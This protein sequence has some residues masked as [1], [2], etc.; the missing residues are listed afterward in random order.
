MEKI[1]DI[2]LR[3]SEKRP[4]GDLTTKTESSSG[5]SKVVELDLSGLRQEV[6][7]A[8]ELAEHSFEAWHGDKQQPTRAACM[9]WLEPKSARALV[10][11]SKKY[12]SGKSYAAAAILNEWLRRDIHRKDPNT[13]IP[14]YYQDGGRILANGPAWQV[15][16]LFIKMNDWFGQ[17]KSMLDGQGA[18]VVGMISMLQRTPFLVMDDLCRSEPT[19]FENDIIYRIVD[20]RTNMRLPFIATTNA[21]PAE[22]S[23]WLWG[24]TASRLKLARFVH[25][26]ERDYRGV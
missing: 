12:G 4:E 21:A 24:A 9:E 1:S 16:A 11:W 2:R 6:G 26:D 19:P 3:E 7:L 25:L 8:G 18:D 10:L 20:Y 15:A 23:E 14:L 22:L 13:G 17:L 5:N